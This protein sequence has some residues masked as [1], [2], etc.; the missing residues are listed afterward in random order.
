MKQTTEELLKEMYMF[1]AFGYKV[2]S[3]F[4]DYGWMHCYDSDRRQELLNRVK[5]LL[6]GKITL[7]EVSEYQQNIH[8]TL[9]KD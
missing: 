8:K 6:K 9:D 7:D 3:N 4:S 5:P 1:L 2:G